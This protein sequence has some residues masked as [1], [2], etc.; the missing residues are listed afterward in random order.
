MV[1]GHRRRDSL[2]LRDLRDR[3][4]IFEEF[5]NSLVAGK[6]E[7]NNIVSYIPLM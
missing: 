3:N 2:E 7:R 5:E 1:I 6:T 4:N